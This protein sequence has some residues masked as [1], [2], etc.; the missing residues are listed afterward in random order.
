MDA[1]IPLIY[2]AFFILT[3]PAL[4]IVGTW[5]WRKHQED[6][7]KHELRRI[8]EEKLLRIPKRMPDQEQGAA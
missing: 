6:K 8:A 3:G 4:V 2:L 7:H 5:M 1:M